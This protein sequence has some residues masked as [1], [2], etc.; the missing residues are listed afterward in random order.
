MI[1]LFSMKRLIM[2]ILTIIVGLSPL[3]FSIYRDSYWWLIIYIWWWFPT[4]GTYIAIDKI[5]K[6]L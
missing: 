1:Y 4:L 5:L 6:K 3:M 2:I